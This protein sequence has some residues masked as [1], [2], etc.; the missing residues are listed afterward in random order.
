MRAF[1]VCAQRSHTECHGGDSCCYRGRCVCL[2]ALRRGTIDPWP[3][4]DAILGSTPG[5][6]FEG[7]EGG[8]GDGFGI[9]VVG[10]VDGLLTAGLAEAV[11]PERDGARSKR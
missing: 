8:G 9:D 5:S 3:P 7:H 2:Y 6:A 1:P 4:R 10:R 11:D